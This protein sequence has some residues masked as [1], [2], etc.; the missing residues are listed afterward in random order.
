MRLV[1]FGVPNQVDEEE[2]VNAMAFATKVLGVNIRCSIL[3]RDDILPSANEPIFIS[4]KEDSEYI[5]AVK[6]IMETCGDIVH[7]VS[8]RTK[9]YELVVKKVIEEPILEVLAFG[10]KS[11]RE[12]SALKDAGGQEFVS[13]CRTALALSKSL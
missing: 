7:N 11:G 1:I 5:Q 2:I 12:L 3:D 4:R 8:D 6:K 10:P 13:I 9:F